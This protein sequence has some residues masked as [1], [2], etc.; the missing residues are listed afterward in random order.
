MLFLSRQE[1]NDIMTRMSKIEEVQKQLSEYHVECEM[2]HQQGEEHR[3]KL[4]ESMDKLSSSNLTLAAS[5]DNMTLRFH[6]SWIKSKNA[7]I[8]WENIVKISVI[9]TGFIALYIA[10]KNV[11]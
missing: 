1:V 6:D 8:T 3:V 5:I 9:A 2:R 10:I 4:Q 11:I 7:W